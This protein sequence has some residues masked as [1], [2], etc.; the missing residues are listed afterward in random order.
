MP[1]GAAAGFG[2]RTPST[3]DAAG[4]SMSS[5]T[6]TPTTTTTTTTTS[7]STTTT[8]STGAGSRPVEPSYKAAR[9][10]SV[11][12]VLGPDETITTAS[13]AAEGFL[14]V[15]TSLGAIL[16]FD[17]QGRFITGRQG[18]HRHDVLCCTVHNGCIITGGADGRIVCY[19]WLTGDCDDLNTPSGSGST[20]ALEP[21]AGVAVSPDFVPPTLARTMALYSHASASPGNPSSPAGQGS[22]TSADASGNAAAAT[23]AAAAAAAAGKKDASAGVLFYARASSGTVV[24][25]QKGLFG[26]SEEVIWSDD[27]SHSDRAWTGADAQKQ[28]TQQ[29]EYHGPMFSRDFRNMCYF[30]PYLFFCWQDS[31]Y[32]YNNAKDKLVGRIG[33]TADAQNGGNIDCVVTPDQLIV[34]WGA[35]VYFCARNFGDRP[36]TVLRHF[37]ARREVAKL[38]LL[39]QHLVMLFE[40][41]PHYHY[42]TPLHEHATDTKAHA[43][44]PIQIAL[45]RLDTMTL[46]DLFSLP[47]NLSGYLIGIFADYTVGQPQAYLSSPLRGTNRWF[48]SDHTSDLSKMMHFPSTFSLALQSSF[49]SPLPVSA[50]ATLSAFQGITR[51]YVVLSNDVVILRSLYVSEQIVWLVE[52]QRFPAAIHMC[53]R[54]RRTRELIEVANEYACHLWDKAQHL[55]AVQLWAEYV[56]PSAPPRFWRIFV[57]RF[58][59]TNQL[60]L[61]EKYLPFNDRSLLSPETYARVLEHHIETGEN[62]ALL[63]CVSYWPVLYPMPRIVTRIIEAIASALQLVQ[64]ALQVEASSA[65]LRGPNH[66]GRS[67]EAAEASFDDDMQFEGEARAAPDQ[68]SATALSSEPATMQAS[69]ETPAPSG[70]VLL[71]SQQLLQGTLPLFWSLFKLFE[72]ANRPV[73]AVQVLIVL[74]RID[75]TASKGYPLAYFHAHNLWS[76]FAA[77]SASVGAVSSGAEQPPGHA[78]PLRSRSHDPEEMLSPN[79]P[80]SDVGG[81]ALSSPSTPTPASSSLNSAQETME[82]LT[83][84]GGHTACNRIGIQTASQLLGSRASQAR[85]LMHLVSLEPDRGCQHLATCA[86]SGL[87]RVSFVLDLFAYHR[88]LL[89]PPEQRAVTRKLELS[90]HPEPDQATT[91]YTAA[92]VLLDT[93]AKNDTVG[94]YKFRLWYLMYCVIQDVKGTQ[95][96]HR[97][98]IESCKKIVGYTGKG[99]RP[100]SMLLRMGSDG[101]DVIAT[102]SAVAAD[103]ELAALSAMEIP[104]SPHASPRKQGSSGRAYPLSGMELPPDSLARRTIRAYQ[105]H[106]HLQQQQQQQQQQPSPPVQLP[107]PAQQQQQSEA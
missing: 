30:A 40:D 107:S 69:T 34:K 49:A 13:V 19:S 75:H 83:L 48:S 45:F 52:Q 55:L 41:F 43:P 32:I 60:H 54:H 103:P 36:L 46:V 68:A 24:R 31:L 47:S 5:A 33:Q 87:L 2:P 98:V 23:A 35:V 82:E 66:S 85:L 16:L 50:T 62:Q 14:V 102:I 27:E 89:Q 101:A 70:R 105:H 6:A 90:E 67:P 20:A 86:M 65:Q 73:E 29:H 96:H 77:E 15:G 80:T 76:I 17:A 106:L 104:P 37:Q 53:Q 92:A 12:E 97:E 38:S 10:Q 25:R 59:Q 11:L 1:S 72:F 88:S 21:V 51:L 78:L 3:S 39:G 79:N 22:G 57:D 61:L 99:S 42:G 28:G 4:A 84:F 64:Q 93:A 74:E 26:F 9:M 58:E 56:L 100:E 18:V 94:L 81:T 7:T 63:E 91:T 95:L 44:A 71:P 8:A